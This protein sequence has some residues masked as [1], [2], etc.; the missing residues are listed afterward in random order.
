[1]DPAM[2]AALASGSGGGAATMA[3]AMPPGM[4]PSMMG[5]APPAPPA[6]GT[7]ADSALP[8]VL[9]LQQAQQGQM[10]QLHDQQASELLSA[11]VAAVGQMPNPLGAA[12]ASEGAMMQPPDQ[13]GA[14]PQD[15]NADQ[16]GG[17]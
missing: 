2:M 17:M 10:Q 9:A 7:P 4:D 3:P 1:M 15:M 12:A 13:L 11:L 14:A 16:T 5:A 6:M 8:V